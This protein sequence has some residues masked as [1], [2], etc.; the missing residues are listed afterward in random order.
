VKPLAVVEVELRYSVIVRHKQIRVTGSAQICCCGQGPATAI[1]ANFRADLLKFPVAE[2]VKQILSPAVLGILK[3]LGHDAR[4]REMPQINVFR[5]VAADE[6]VQESVAVVIEP[7]GGVR[8][9]PGR[10][11]SLLG[12]AGEAVALIIVKQLGATPL[13]EKQIF[14]SI[15]V[16][17]SPNRAG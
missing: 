2:I 9:D 13:D 17:V 15:I 10:Q 6:E 3:A 11:S 1:N 8:I 5:I 4:R 7:D 12:Y 16:V 14:I